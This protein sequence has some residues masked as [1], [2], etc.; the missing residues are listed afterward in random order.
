V[1]PGRFELPS[2]APK[3]YNPN[4]S[5]DWR[6]DHDNFLS[7]L[8]SRKYNRVYIQ[9]ILSYLRRYVGVL[10]GPMDVINAFH[11]L[12][13]GQQ[14]NLDRGVRA[15]FNFYEDMGID[16]D[17]LNAFRKVIPPEQE[18]VDL[19]VP[20]E[21]DI[22]DSLRRVQRAPLKYRA[23]YHL[24]LDSGLRIV[25][26]VKLINNFEGSVEVKGS[27]RCE[28]GYFRGSKL[29]YFGYMTHETLDLVEKV[30]GDHIEEQNASHYYPKIKCVCGKYLRKFA[31]DTMISEKL[32]IP[33][34]VADF[35]Q[36]RVPKTIGARHYTRLMRQAD[37][38]YPRYAEYIKQLR[39]KAGLIPA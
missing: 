24:L 11:G 1:G 10:S 19:K 30:A 36:G 34:S 39:Q 4:L 27:L 17:Y 26:G 35:I 13:E 2:Q 3:A 15:L 21:Q 37:N 38:F 28:L 8:E 14:H 25:E 31:F 20:E 12:T 32:N 33:E 5:L 29:A 9:T 23:L 6:R 16:E 7:W 18:F 22:L